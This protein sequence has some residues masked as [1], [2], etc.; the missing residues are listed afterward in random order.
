MVY[1]GPAGSF[2]T[3]S[4][5]DDWAVSSRANSACHCFIFASARAR[6]SADGALHLLLPPLREAAELK[7]TCAAE[8][9]PAGAKPVAAAEENPE[10]DFDPE[11]TGSAASGSASGGCDFSRG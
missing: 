7:P 11:G 2:S 3:S 8:L 1:D 5:G 9:K 6:A 10:F 4:I